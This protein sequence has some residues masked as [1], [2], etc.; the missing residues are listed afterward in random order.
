M[1]IRFCDYRNQVIEVGNYI[2]GRCSDENLQFRFTMF[3]IIFH[4]QHIL[5]MMNKYFINWY[6]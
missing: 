6:Q 3:Y 4:E 2:C 5:L 1:P